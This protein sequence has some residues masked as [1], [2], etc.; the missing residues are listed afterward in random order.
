MIEKLISKSRIGEVDNVARQI[1]NAFNEGNWSADVHLS[2][3]VNELKQESTA[4]S[5]AIRRTRAESELE[6]KDEVRDAKI[7]AIYYLTQGFLHHPDVAVKTAAQ[8]VS[9]VFDKYTLS[10]LS[11]SYNQQSALTVSLLNELEADE[12]KPHVAALPGLAVIIGELRVAQSDF[13]ASQLAYLGDKAHEGTQLNATELK[14][15][16]VKIINNKLVVYLRAM[17]QVDEA[18]YAGLG[19][20]IQ[21]IIDTNNRAVKKRR[22]SVVESEV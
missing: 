19:R 8:V 12:L 1:I 4:L 15:Q 21:E 2:N 14:E 7:R 3:T 17:V 22:Q 5:S 6:A 13:E 20:L 16:V 9:K 11:E 18:R 10:L